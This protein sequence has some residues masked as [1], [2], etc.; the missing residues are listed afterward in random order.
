MLIATGGI[1][2]PQQ[3]STV[4]IDEIIADGS[5][6][7]Y[8]LSQAPFEDKPEQQFVLVKVNN[9]ILEGGY[10]QTFKVKKNLKEY[11]LDLTQIP[12][13]RIFSKFL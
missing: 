1:E 13:A 4:T 7:S 12:V 3:Y 10:S 2:I 5:S 9:Q 8:Q 11:Q 6:T